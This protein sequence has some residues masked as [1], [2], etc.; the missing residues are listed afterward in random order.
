MGRAPPIIRSA[1]PLQGL[2]VLFGAVSVPDS[3]VPCQHAHS[4]A[5]VIPRYLRGYLVFVS[6][7]KQSLP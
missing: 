4:G 2:V 7:V 5:G 1:E 6:E 3:D